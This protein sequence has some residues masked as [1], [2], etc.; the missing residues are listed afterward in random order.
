MNDIL[1]TIGI[2][3][4]VYLGYLIIWVIIVSLAYFLSLLIRKSYPISFISGLSQIAVYILFTIFGI[5][6]LVYS[7]QLLVSF[8]WLELF[9]MGF[10]GFGIIA[11]LLNILTLPFY[12]IPLFFQEK[13][14]ETD[15]GEDIERAEILDKKGKVLKVIEGETAI[16][17]NI[18]KYFIAFFSLNLLSIFIFPTKGEHLLALDYITKPFFQVIG[19]TFIFGLPYLIYHRVK[20]KS[21]FPEDKRYFF[22]NT[23]KLSLYILVPSLVV[24]LLI[25]IITGTL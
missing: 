14:S 2:I 9:I 5:W 23:W 4:V 6:A 21:F 10:I 3:L 22:I 16:K 8:R 12:G 18:A 15:F 19:G 20:Y 24:L 11:G 1:R 17:R 7:I 13:I 25:S